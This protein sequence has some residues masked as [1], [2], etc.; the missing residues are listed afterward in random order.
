[1]NLHAECFFVFFIFMT[2]GEQPGHANCL[3]SNTAAWQCKKN[4]KNMVRVMPGYLR[5][6]AFFQQSDQPVP[7]R[8][9]STPPPPHDIIQRTITQV[10][11]PYTTKT[12][13]CTSQQPCLA[14]G[15]LRVLVDGQ[16]A[17]GMAGSMESL[18]NP[19]GFM[20]SAANLPA[21]CQPFGGD[22]IWANKFAEIV[23]D[24]ASSRRRLRY[25]QIKK[26][27]VRT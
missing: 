20:V 5:S 26:L 24:V 23:G 8:P 27:K 15:A 22:L 19:A 21:E 12:D 13:G 25:S 1:M 11:D 4:K 2:E 3:V 17:Y 14:N 6:L 16:E 18:V 7:R 9:H 10:K